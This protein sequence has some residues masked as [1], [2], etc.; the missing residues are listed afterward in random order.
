MKDSSLL[1][2]VSLI[3]VYAP[4]EV[5]NRTMEDAFFVTLESVVDQCPRRDTFLVLGDFTASSETDRDGY[6]E[7]CGGSQGSRTVNQNSTKFLDLARS[8][9]FRV[10]GSWLQHPQ[11]HRWT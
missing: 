6:N 8:H 10:A 7:T 4:A 9:G 2:V 11:A 3:S 1:G 5:S